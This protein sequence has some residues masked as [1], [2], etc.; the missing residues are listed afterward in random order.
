MRL[1]AM[2]LCKHLGVDIGMQGTMLSTVFEDNNGCISIATAK[3]MNPRTKHI[4]TVYH[5]FHSFVGDKPDKIKIQKINTSVQWADMFT[6]PLE[7]EIFVKIW[8]LIM[9]W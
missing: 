3:R 5:W 9:G 8:K 6:K 2:E 7:K 1:T 4:A